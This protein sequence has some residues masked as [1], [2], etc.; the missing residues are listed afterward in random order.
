MERSVR[1]DANGGTD[2]DIEHGFGTTGIAVEYINYSTWAEDQRV[3]KQATIP[4]ENKRD[5]MESDLAAAM[6]AKLA[7]LT[8]GEAVEP[9]NFKLA[10][11]QWVDENEEEQQFV[12]VTWRSRSTTQYQIQQSDDMLSWTDVG[13][14]VPGNNGPMWLN[15]PVLGK[16][17]YRLVWSPV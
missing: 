3:I 6:A 9:E 13:D 2:T 7:P 10:A 1:N 17:F 12:Q 8:P 15:Q 11:Y 14:P 4:I 5:Q 16:V